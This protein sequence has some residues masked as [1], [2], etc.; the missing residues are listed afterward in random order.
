MKRQDVFKKLSEVFRDVFDDESI[1]V[2]EV[3]SAD[4]IEDWDSL[5]HINLIVSVEKKFN[6]KFTMNEVVGMKNAGEMADVIMERG[7]EEG[8]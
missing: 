4:D 2:T 1:V 7:S 8:L 3:T 5:E 6:M